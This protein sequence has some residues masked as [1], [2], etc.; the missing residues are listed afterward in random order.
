MSLSNEELKMLFY[1]PRKATHN[2]PDKLILELMNEKNMFNNDLTEEQ[3]IKQY[4]CKQ[5]EDIIFYDDNVLTLNKEKYNTILENKISTFSEELQ[6]Q[7]VNVSNFIFKDHNLNNYPNPLSNYKF[8]EDGYKG[9]TDAGQVAIVDEYDDD[10]ISLSLESNS[11]TS[12]KEVNLFDALEC[13]P[14]HW[15]VGAHDEKHFY[16]IINIAQLFANI[17]FKVSYFHIHHCGDFRVQHFKPDCPFDIDYDK[18]CNNINDIYGKVS[19]LEP[20][21]IIYI[22]KEY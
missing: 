21:F 17:G 12:L 18:H 14:Y 4:I 20:L 1:K 10:T 19:V 13:N 7:I 9:T 15:C 8:K 22:N 16:E 6:L 3:F 5:N 2:L 11:H